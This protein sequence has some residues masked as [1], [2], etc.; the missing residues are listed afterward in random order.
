MTKSSSRGSS[1]KSFE[2]RNE[3]P[4]TRVGLSGTGF[5]ARGIYSL[6]ES[7]PD[8]EVTGVL[9]RR[10]P[11]ASAETFPEALL[12]NSLDQLVEHADIVLECSGDTVHA[13]K[14]MIAAGEAGRKIVT[15]NS[16]AQITVGSAMVRMGFDITEAHGDQPGCLAELHY[17]ALDMAFKPLA[18]IN[19]KG[20]LNLTPTREDMIYWGNRQG[21]SL[22]QVT[23]FTDG[24]KLQVEQALVANGLGA[25][26]AKQGL[27]GGSVENLADLDYMADAARELGA[28]ISDYVLNPGGPPGVLILAES[29]VADLAEGYMPLT[30]L[31]TTKETAYMLLRPHHMVH[32][33]LGKTLRRVARGE[34]PLLTNGHTPRVTVAAVAKRPLEAGTVIEEALGGFEV[35]GEAIELD[36]H[37]DV[38]PITLLDGGVLK[39]SVEPGQVIYAGDVDLEETRAHRLYRKTVDTLSAPVDATAA[40]SVFTPN[41]NGVP[42]TTN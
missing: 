36:G 34:A 25:R 27:I 41:G 13:T 24:G 20:F 12:T 5:I 4:V 14:V 42:L 7:M 30:R 11:S 3:Y 21:L 40:P 18:Y 16:E 32:L 35:R 28:P 22:R 33:E 8:F 38:V 2:A 9:T 26:I 31:L 29:A 17:E 1:R 39:N 15:M 6:I 19:L 37:E 10:D 23:S